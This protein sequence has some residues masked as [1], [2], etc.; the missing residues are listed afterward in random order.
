M[1]KIAARSANIT[2]RT[3]S[4]G[5]SFQGNIVPKRVDPKISA[6]SSPSHVATTSGRFVAYNASKVSIVIDLDQFDAY[7]L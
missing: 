3:R 4:F 1:I 2:K 5:G 7:R 6:R